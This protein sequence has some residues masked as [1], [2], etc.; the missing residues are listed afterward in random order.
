[1]GFRFSTYAS[2]WIRHAI[3]RALA[4]KGR[5]IRLPVHMIDAQHRLNKAR[6][7]LTG[8]LGR[9]PT[10]EELA[11]TTQ[12]PLDKVEKMRTWMIEQPVSLDR[13]VGDEDGRVL[14]EVLEDPD[15]DP[16]TTSD[17][18]ALEALMA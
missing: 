10:T 5:E 3:S 11:L 15:R 9:N 7:Q 6:R 14:A 2:W 1:K 17:D 12:M 13:P 8:E 16:T 4:D 18:M